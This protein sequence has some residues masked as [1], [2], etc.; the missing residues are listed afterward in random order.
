MG[1]VKTFTDLGWRPESI[2]DERGDTDLEPEEEYEPGYRMFEGP[3][4]G[5]SLL[6]GEG[7]IWH[8]PLGSI[9]GD[10]IPTCR[11]CGRP[12]VVRTVSYLL[13]D[14]TRFTGHTIRAGHQEVAPLAAH[15]YCLSCDRSGQDTVIGTA[16]NKPEKVRRV[17]APAP[18]LRG[19]VG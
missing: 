15:V 16:E 14:G 18:G 1:R 9:V 10:G 12:V 19:G 2:E 3:K 17:Y 4:F 5:F 7:G 6:L 13:H 8:G 11:W